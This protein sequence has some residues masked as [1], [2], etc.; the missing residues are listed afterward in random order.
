VRGED[1]FSTPAN[2]ET[3]GDANDKG[4][5]QVQGKAAISALTS[6][7]ITPA[8]TANTSTHAAVGNFFLRMARFHKEDGIKLQFMVTAARGNCALSSRST[9]MRKP[10]VQVFPA[11]KKHSAIAGTSSG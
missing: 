4:H 7:T 9:C 1:E 5:V 8:D 6:Q 10:R 11:L 2:L 3:G